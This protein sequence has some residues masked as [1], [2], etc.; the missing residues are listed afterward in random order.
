MANLVLKPSTGAGNSVI[1]KDQAGG[2]VLTTADSGATLGNSTQD[3]ITR[4]GTVTSGTIGSGVTFP[5]GHVLQVQQTVLDIGSNTTYDYGE[6]SGWPTTDWKASLTTKQ[7]NSTHI[8]WMDSGS[9]YEDQ[10]EWVG[11]KWKKYIGSTE[12][13]IYPSGTSH[14]WVSYTAGGH[15]SHGAKAYLSHSPA[16]SAGT[17]IDYRL[18]VGNIFMHHNA[19]PVVI[20]VME[21]V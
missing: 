10:S 19:F 11:L 9:G 15:A 21:V 1:V 2:A 12:T 8:M 18:Y 16:V 3:N 4:V 17:L 20:Y 7:V 5:A 6:S 13:A 14:E